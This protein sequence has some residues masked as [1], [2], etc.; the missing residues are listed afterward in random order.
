MA[1]T[2]SHHER[3]NFIEAKFYGRVELLFGWSYLYFH[4]E[5]I[6]QK[7]L[8]RLKYNN[9]PEIGVE[10]GRMYA[11]EI[12][13]LLQKQQLDAIVPVPLHY[14]KLKKRGYNQSEKFAE[15]ISSITGIPV[16]TALSRTQSTETQT[17]KNRLERWNNV[18]SIFKIIKEEIHGKRV[19]LV[20]DVITTGATIEACASVLVK[21]N[22]QVAVLSLAT[23][24]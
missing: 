16:I 2:N 10:L 17:A 13:Q 23:V 7:L 24:K 14:K 11:S 4:Q 22:C 12:I 15:G 19:L 1:K 9:M 6:A 20:D 8:H 18:N 21:A 5:G 3:K